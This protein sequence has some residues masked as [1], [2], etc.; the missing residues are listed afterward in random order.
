MRNKFILIFLC[1]AFS[2]G[3]FA[4]DRILDLSQIHEIIKNE[5]LRLFSM[6]FPQMPLDGFPIE[7][8]S[9]G[10]VVTDNLGGVKNWSISEQGTISLLGVKGKVLYEFEYDAG[11]GIFVASKGRGDEKLVLTFIIAPSNKGFD[12]MSL[13]KCLHRLNEKPEI[14]SR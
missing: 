2:Q 5:D 4:K 8:L 10:V 11:D 12:M 7:L 1:I 14:T 9:S 6:V 13:S 3:V